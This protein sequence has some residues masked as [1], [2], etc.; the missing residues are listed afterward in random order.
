MKAKACALAI[1]IGALAIEV[2]ERC[3]LLV[4]VILIASGTSVAPGLSITHQE[5]L[6]MFGLYYFFK[7]EISFC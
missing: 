5:L 7:I 1:G 2:L 3:T 6:M 4:L